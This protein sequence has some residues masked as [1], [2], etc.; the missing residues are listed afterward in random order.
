ADRDPDIACGHEGHAI[1]FALVYLGLE[2]DV[3]GALGLHGFEERVAVVEQRSGRV[4]AL[5]E[6]AGAEHH[7]DEPHAVALR[8]ARETVAGALGVT[9]LDAVDGLIAREQAVAVRL[10]V[11]VPGELALGIP[12][13]VLGI[14]ADDGARNESQVRGRGIVTW[15]RSAPAVLPVRVLQA[16]A[17]RGFIH[18]L[19]ESVF[20]AS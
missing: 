19:H 8:R 3:A 13:V 4:F 14:V 16:H 1:R 7:G 10:T 12:A 20:G 9:G 11:L 6:A 15:S 5:L 2:H 18:D 17:A